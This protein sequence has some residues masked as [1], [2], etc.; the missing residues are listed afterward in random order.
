[1]HKYL[2]ELLKKIKKKFFIKK[3]I[4]FG[5]RAKGDYFLDSDVDV[6]IVSPDFEGI[7]FSDRIGEI[8]YEWEGPVDLEALC[9]TPEEFERKKKQKGVVKEAVKTG[10]EIK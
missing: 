7:F 5:S 8:I 2:K 9:Y 6:L 1:M 4:L 3:V 10:I